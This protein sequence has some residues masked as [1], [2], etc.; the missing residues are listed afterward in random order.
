MGMVR[1][2]QRPDKSHGTY[3]G[4]ANHLDDRLFAGDVDALLRRR[5]AAAAVPAL[6]PTMR[7]W[8]V[9]LDGPMTPALAKALTEDKKKPGDADTAGVAGDASG[10][11]TGIALGIA[12]A[13][14]PSM[15]D[16][17]LVALLRGAGVSPATQAGADEAAGEAGVPGEAGAGAPTLTVTLDERPAAAGLVLGANERLREDVGRRRWGRGSG[18]GRG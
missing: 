16:A 3:V 12:R 2:R 17:E 9:R 8:T 6:R 5:A 4:A 7:A 11:G 1:G 13:P 14:G 18:G 15:T 10:A